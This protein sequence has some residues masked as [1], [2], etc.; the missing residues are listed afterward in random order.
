MQEAN[1]KN[2]KGPF[3]NKQNTLKNSPKKQPKY[4]QLSFCIV[5]KKINSKRC[6][7]DNFYYLG[8]NAS[9]FIN[10][11]DNV[12]I[13]PTQSKSNASTIRKI[14]ADIINCRQNNNSWKVYMYHKINK[15]ISGQHDLL[16]R[17]SKSVEVYSSKH[18]YLL[19][20]KRIT[21]ILIILKYLKSKYDYTN[22]YESPK[23]NFNVT[24]KV[25]TTKALAKEYYNIC[26]LKTVI[27][28][29]ISNKISH[30]YSYHQIRYIIIFSLHKSK[31]RNINIGFLLPTFNN[32][33]IK[34]NPRF[35]KFLPYNSCT[36]CL[37]KFKTTWSI[38][39][40]IQL[41]FERIPYIFKSTGVIFPTSISI[42]NQIIEFSID[43]Q[44]KNLETSAIPRTLSVKEPKYLNSADPAVAAA[45]GSNIANQNYLSSKTESNY[46]N[47]ACK[48]IDPS[49]VYNN[50]NNGSFNNIHYDTL[51][52]IVINLD[53]NSVINENSKGEEMINKASK[54]TITSKEVTNNNISTNSNKMWYQLTQVLDSAVKGVQKAFVT[55]IIELK[56]ILTNYVQPNNKI[57][58]AKTENIDNQEQENINS[59]SNIVLD[60]QS[61]FIK[62][63]VRDSLKLSLNEVEM[64]PSTSIH[65]KELKPHPI[66]TEYVT[67]SKRRSFSNVEIGKGDTR[68]P[69]VPLT[70]TRE[71]ERFQRF[72][73][74]MSILLFFIRENLISA[75]LSV[76]CFIIAYICLIEMITFA[77]SIDNG[78]KRWNMRND[79]Y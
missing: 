35:Q 8:E 29:R 69:T 79:I 39:K 23:P 5:P 42:N 43:E 25:K 60:T 55:A 58:T 73:N 38:N 49:S 41:F 76:P 22:Y 24:G 44:C 45:S 75:A 34:S 46:L 4:S 10:Y 36:I 31:N 6:S 33:A 77:R 14:G 65:L 15:M 70:S 68:A 53:S 21:H 52:E 71:P 48:R 50:E 7:Y 28:S 63:K 72:K 47:K 18:Y 66:V 1:I 67:L 74:P 26:L 32:I 64:L 13:S 20:I 37:D 12:P 59:E 61:N 62:T 54:I 51:P 11:I 16:L 9:N 27:N 2:S 19:K 3:S 78:M 30:N 40:T 17:S 57:D 56:K